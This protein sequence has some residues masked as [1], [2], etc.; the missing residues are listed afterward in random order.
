M[1]KFGKRS[2]SI[3][4][5]LHYLL[6]NI[7]DEAIKNPPHDFGLHQGQRSIKLQYQYYLDKKSKIDGITKRGYHNYT[8]ALAFDFHCSTK[9]HTW[10]FKYLEKIARHIQKVALDK[11]QI[12]LVWGGDWKKFKDGPHI[13]LPYSFKQKAEKEKSYVV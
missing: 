9:G 12:K 4:A 2:N 6:Q 11:F 8:P 1:S 10:D 7:L 5:G 3:K 13:Q